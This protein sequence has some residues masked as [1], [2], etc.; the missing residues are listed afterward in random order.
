LT[1]GSRLP[2]V[3]PEISAA[4]FPSLLLDRAPWDGRRGVEVC[5][6]LLFL[7]KKKQKDF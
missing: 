7:K 5:K 4:R 3:E 6:I 1:G 2:F